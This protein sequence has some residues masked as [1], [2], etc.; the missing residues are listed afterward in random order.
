M[1]IQHA[2][3]TAERILPADS[4]ELEVTSFPLLTG[5]NKKQYFVML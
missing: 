3:L 1:R 4:E 2:Q 5:N